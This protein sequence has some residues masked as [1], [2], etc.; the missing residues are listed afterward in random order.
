MERS[1]GRGLAQAWVVFA[2]QQIGRAKGLCQNRRSGRHDKK[3][4]MTCQCNA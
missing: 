4:D 3:R 1:M 2:G